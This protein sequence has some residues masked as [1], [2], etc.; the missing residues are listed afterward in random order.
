MAYY[1]IS[2]KERVDR[3]C[4]KGSFRVNGLAATTL[5]SE[6]DLQKQFSSQL[7]VIRRSDW[8]LQ[9]RG[10]LTTLNGSGS[11]VSGGRLEN[12]SQHLCVLCSCGRRNPSAIY[13]SCGWQSKVMR[14][15]R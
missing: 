6:A 4:R 11:Y 7:D 2:A 12:V 3:T 15:R 5:P 10:L 9:G 8:H 1:P 14:P 13:S